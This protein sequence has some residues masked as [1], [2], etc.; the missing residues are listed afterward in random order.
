MMLHVEEDV[1]VSVSK[2]GVAERSRVTGLSR[3]DSESLAAS[4]MPAAW[5]SLR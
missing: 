3:N 5:S 4:S 2:L 1:L